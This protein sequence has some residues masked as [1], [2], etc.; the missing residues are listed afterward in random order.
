VSA[1]INESHTTAI[2]ERILCA[3]TGSLAPE[4]ARYF[5]T[6]RVPQADR[7][8]VNDLSA[9]AR[10]GTLTADEEAELDEYLLVDSFLTSLKAK[11]R[12]S[13]QQVAGLD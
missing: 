5:L 11:A 12:I 9:K 1:V 10:A 7:E 2:W 13:L 4:Q 3:E 6:L 8:R